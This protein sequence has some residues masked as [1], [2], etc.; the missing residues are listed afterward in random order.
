MV[1]CSLRLYLHLNPVETRSTHSTRGHM[2]IH[3]PIHIHITSYLTH[4]I[5]GDPQNK[6]HFINPNETFHVSNNASL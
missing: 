3:H 5:D 2:N 6:V 1:C 4:I